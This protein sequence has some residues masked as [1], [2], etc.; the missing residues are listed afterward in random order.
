[1][2]KDVDVLYHE[3]TYGNDE[4]RRSKETYHSTAEDAARVAYA[5]NAGKLVIGHFSSRYKNIS[6]LL[7]EARSIFP[8]TEAAEDGKE[9][10]V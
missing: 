5:A 6:P 4:K 2:I 8:N 7:E 9:F 1:M 10:H 3:A